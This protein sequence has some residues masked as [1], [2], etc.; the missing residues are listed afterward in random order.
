MNR[1]GFTLAEVL[2]VIVFIAVVS[3]ITAPIILDLIEESRQHAAV[4]NAYGYV[5]GINKYYETLSYDTGDVIALEGQYDI[6]NGK[7]SG[8]YADE[9]DVPVTGSVP[10][11][12]KLVY[13]DDKLV[14]GCL[15]FNEYRVGYINGTF[16][17]YGKGSCR[18]N[19]DFEHDSWSQIAYNYS[20]DNNAYDNEIGKTRSLSFRHSGNNYTVTLRLY[21]TSNPAECRVD[22]F[23]QTACGL[24]VGFESLAYG[25]DITNI[26][27]V[28]GGW[29]NTTNN[30]GWK[31]SRL[32]GLLN[33]SVDND[34]NPN[35]LYS[36]LPAELRNV[37]IP[38]SPIVSGAGSGDNSDDVVSGTDYIYIPSAYEVGIDDVRD[39]K[40]NQTRTLDYYV[41]HNTAADRIKSNYEGA[42]PWWLRTANH[43]SDTDYLVILGNGNIGSTLCTG[44]GED[45][46][47]SATFRI[48]VK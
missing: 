42:K 19:G 27:M 4:D 40:K 18:I 15:T 43:N 20:I 48:G 12:G 6:V 33:T 34:N 30:G 29:Y 17:I 5:D 47:I 7:L 11:N 1:K 37:I 41:T 21:N 10:I 38:T 39:S 16:D 44:F 13:E 3:I 2:A 31:S 14:S 9:L 46:F 24:V 28:S 45:P 26:W 32:R 8:L 23:S 25:E 35:N 36:S 22:G